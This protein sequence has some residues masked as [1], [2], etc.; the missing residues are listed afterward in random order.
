MRRK[1]EQRGSVYFRGGSWY[2]S[3]RTLA[4]DENGNVQWK[5]VWRKVEGA[6]SKRDAERK[7][8][9]QH[10]ASANALCKVPQG[11]ATLKQFIDLR[12]RPEH[13]DLLKKSGRIHYESILRNHILP[14]LGAMPLRDIHSRVI[15]TLLSAKFQSGKLSPQTITHIRNVLSAIFRHA[16]HLGY[17]EGRLPTEGLKLPAM[18]RR[19]RRALT[20]DQV[21]ML[22]EAIH[23][24]HRPLIIVL[25]Q[26]GMRIGEA[27]GLR[28]KDVNLTD[29][30]RIVDG[31]ALPPN[32]IWVRSSVTKGERTTPKS[33]A[34]WRKI[35]LTAEA[36][37]A[38][39][40]QYERTEFRG[41]DHPVFCSNVGTPLD[42]H[43]VSSRSLRT[44]GR[45]IGLPWVTFH[46]LRHTCATLADRVLTP[47]EKQKI[48]GHSTSA[49]SM[50]YTH[51]ELERVRRAM[52]QMGSSGEGRVM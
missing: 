9:E 40:E 42:Y 2:I 23:P 6:T 15:Q 32:S 1:G 48:L 18:V 10:V 17:Y 27:C 39:M 19:E 12:F 50:H 30:W 25:A 11:L 43:N 20:W 28:W 8:Y 52:E 41:E 44:A 22:A 51:P 31:Q 13:I 5:S 33:P 46:S 37:V 38:L 21:K 4:V 49:M 14:S 16:I 35:P 34:S 45:K 47:A 29:E 26:T 36:W 7:G 3:F 24:K